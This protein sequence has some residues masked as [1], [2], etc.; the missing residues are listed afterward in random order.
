MSVNPK[1]FAFTLVELLVVIA[2]ISLLAA[3]ALPAISKAREAA[4]SSQCQ[5]NLKNIGV[6][7]QQFSLSDPQGRMC[8]GAS[9]YRRD[10]CMDT[11]GWVADI[12]N[13]GNGNLNEMLCPSNPLKGS[14]KL[15]DLLGQNTADGKDGAPGSRLATGICGKS[16]WNGVSGSGGGTLFAGTAGGTEDRAELI[17]RYFME[18]GYN[19]NYAAG[20]H[21]VRG[22]LKIN[23][24]AASTPANVVSLGGQK[25]L[26]GSLGP[27]KAATLDRSRIPS[28]NIGIIGDAAPGDLDEAILTQDL[29]YDGADRNT[30]AFG[31][32]QSSRSF[33]AAGQLL[34]EAFNDGPAFYDTSTQTLDLIG[35][36]AVLNTQIECERGQPTTG[37]CASP[38]SGTN[39]YLQDTR[40]WFATHAGKSNILMAD[41]SVKVFYDVNGDGFLNPG[42]PV[43]N[44]LS[45][46]QYLGIGYR[47]GVVEMQ[48]DQFF[49]GVFLDDTYFKG[50]FE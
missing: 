34:T 10:G 5:A 49:G 28:N 23:I 35:A 43:E 6:A 7:L 25:G 4:R 17:S 31:D 2:I 3:L 26:A 18:Q 19:T 42:F 14:E 37:A 12:V 36:G 33:I 24:D 13:T 45:E 20:W 48:K 15:N 32:A 8:S 11:Y 38:T 1:R 9:D 47:D 30:F 41:G 46:E 22:G 40:D 50:I 27:L 44:N 16:D 29:S 39:T 21:L